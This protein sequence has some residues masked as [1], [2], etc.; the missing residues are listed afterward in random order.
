MTRRTRNIRT[1][2]KQTKAVFG[3]RELFETGGK[4]TIPRIPLARNQLRRM[5]P[6]FLFSQW[7]GVSV[8]VKEQTCAAGPQ[9]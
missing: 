7:D 8:C 1:D 2:P 3:R 9:G 5:V 6:G 4:S